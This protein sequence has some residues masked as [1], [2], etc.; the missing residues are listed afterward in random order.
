MGNSNS[1]CL[2]ADG[3]N[4]N[5]FEKNFTRFLL[6]DGMNHLPFSR[7]DFPIKE[8]IEFFSYR[9]TR[10]TKAGLQELQKVVGLLKNE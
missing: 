4:K 9:T 2:C 3:K 8:V 10:I 1:N 7:Y 6:I 5:F